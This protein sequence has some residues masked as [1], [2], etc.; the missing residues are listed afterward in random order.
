MGLNLISDDKRLYYY[1]RI[2]IVHLPNIGVDG[3]VCVLM[4][5]VPPVYWCVYTLEL[6]S[7]HPGLP[8]PHAAWVAATP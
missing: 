5:R 1:I 6:S 8:A 2:L 7:Q 4:L 3:C